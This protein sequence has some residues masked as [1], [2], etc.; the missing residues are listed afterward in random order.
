MINKMNAIVKEPGEKGFKLKQVPIPKCKPNEV[1]IKVYSTSFCGT[2]V[3]IYYWMPWAQENVKSSVIVGHEFVG[4]VV[5]VGSLATQY[6]IGQMVTAEDRVPCNN[7]YYCK[8]GE[9]HLCLQGN[10]IGIDIDGSC[11]EYVV[12][13]EDLVVPVD[14]KLPKEIVA[15]MVY[16]GVAVHAGSAFDVEGKDVLI[17]ESDGMG[18]MAAVTAKYAGAKTITLVDTNPF[19]LNMAKQILPQINVSSLEGDEKLED[20]RDKL[21]IAHGFDVCIELCGSKLDLNE[22]IKNTKRNGEI[23]ILG[24]YNPNVTVDWG[25]IGRKC[26]TIKGI[27]GRRIFKDWNTMIKIIESD[28]DLKPLITDFFEYE[29]F[30]KAI[31][32]I[33]Q[34]K[35]GRV[36]MDWNKKNVGRKCNQ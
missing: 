28:I 29:D 4:E 15:S 14:A 11:A 3:M 2:D 34:G 22:I 10:H 19:N 6:Q 20:L 1:K 24:T 25:V 26:I 23:A 17:S 7:C 21:N 30:D 32:S 16:W 31:E 13:R 18:I 9:R 12:I 33:I 36:V 5:E 8:A 27:S 35:C